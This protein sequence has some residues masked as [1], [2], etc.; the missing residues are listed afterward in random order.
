MYYTTF[1]NIT[2]YAEVFSKL[3]NW[4]TSKNFE[5]KSMMKS[6]FSKAAC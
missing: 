4:N 5:K 3:A 1:L 6:I 2:G